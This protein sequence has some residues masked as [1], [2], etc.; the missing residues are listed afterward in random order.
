MK[1]F[2]I[3]YRVGRKLDTRIVNTWA[4]D[5]AVAVR[6][7]QAQGFVVLECVELAR[8]DIPSARVFSRYGM[9]R[10]TWANGDYAVV[11]ASCVECFHESGA[12]A[13]CDLDAARALFIAHGVHPVA[14]QPADLGQWVRV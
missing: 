1:Q 8:W 10:Y 14:V 2:R 5:R 3:E 12:R 13:P 7:M 11:S 9:T 4:V 6:D